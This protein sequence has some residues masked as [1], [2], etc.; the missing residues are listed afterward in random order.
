M[1]LNS[2]VPIVTGIPPCVEQL[3]HINKLKAIAKS[4]KEDVG[5]VVEVLE[6]AVRNA[7][8]KKAKADG[9]ISSSILDKR[10]KM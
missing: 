8:D 7:I 6:E 3:C 9:G 10:L 5:N 4:T 2:H 1:E